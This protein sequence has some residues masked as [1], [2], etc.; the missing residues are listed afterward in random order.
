MMT[1][2]RFFASAGALLLSLA[3]FSAGNAAPPAAPPNAKDAP[4]VGTHAPDNG[5][6]TTIIS[7]QESPIG[8]Y[9]TPWKNAFTK[10]GM[11]APRNHRLQVMP[12]P[13]DPDT[14]HLQNLYYDTITAFRAKELAAQRGHPASGGATSVHPASPTH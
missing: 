4:K 2:T 6:G 11:Y 10:Q 12:E 5:S 9:I 7:G 14:F 8:L 3:A 1:P 13:V